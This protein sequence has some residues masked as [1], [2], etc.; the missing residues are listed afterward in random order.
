MIPKHLQAYISNSQLFL[1]AVTHRSYCNEHPKTENYERLEFLGDAVLEYLMSKELYERFPDQQE[2]VLTAMR[3]KLVQ[4]FSLSRMAIKLCLGDYLR[5][6]KGEEK[7]EGRSNPALLEDAYEAL[8]GAIYLDKGMASARK[9]LSDTLFPEI[10]ALNASDLKDPKS[11]FQELVQ[12]KGMETPTYDVVKETGPDHDKIFTV[13][14]MVEN[15]E[16]GRGSGNS[17]QRAQTAAAREGLLR[18]EEKRNIW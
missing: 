5:L 17:K 8:I 12:A 7:S 1:T 13:V 3:S 18:L 10:D 9:F 15:K 14:L 16:W 4:T 11:L 2:G 6:S